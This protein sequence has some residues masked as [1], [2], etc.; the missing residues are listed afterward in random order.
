MSF[1]RDT[2]TARLT[3]AKR[4]GTREEHPILSPTLLSLSHA[5]P[6]PKSS[7]GT[8]ETNPFVAQPSRA[9]QVMHGESSAQTLSPSSRNPGWSC[10][11]DLEVNQI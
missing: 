11:Y 3:A 4:I 6:W 7:Q 9:E 2:A 1:W 8:G 5:P 10:S